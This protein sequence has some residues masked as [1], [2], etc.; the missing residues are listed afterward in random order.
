MIIHS[1]YSIRLY[2]LY[3]D[4]KK[5]EIKNLGTNKASK[6]S[7]LVSEILS[8]ASQIACHYGIGIVELGQV[9]KKGKPP[10]NSLHISHY[11]QLLFL[12]LS[13]TLSKN[14]PN[15]VYILGKSKCTIMCKWLFSLA[16]YQI[17]Q[18][19]NEK[20]KQASIKKAS[21]KQVRT[22]KRNIKQA[23]MSI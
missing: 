11:D 23:S 10:R 7:C 8:T 18:S 14:V 12:L 19:T 2:T 9:T 15:N 13:W 4:K 1:C 3:L 20:N 22:K 5:D 16:T 17:Q 21:R 6:K